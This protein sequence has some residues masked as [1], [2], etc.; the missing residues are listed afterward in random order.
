MPVLIS[1]MIFT[2]DR[3]TDVASKNNIKLLNRG[4]SDIPLG[5]VVF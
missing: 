1:P 2:G 3:T 5:E 4:V